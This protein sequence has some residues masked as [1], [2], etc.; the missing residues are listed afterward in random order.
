MSEWWKY[1]R[2]LF[3]GNLALTS[4]AYALNCYV[5]PGYFAYS[6]TDRARPAIAGP[7]LYPYMPFFESTLRVPL[8]KNIVG[9]SVLH[10]KNSEA[11]IVGLLLVD[12]ISITVDY[13][14]IDD[15]ACFLREHDNTVADVLSISRCEDVD[16]SFLEDEEH[17]VNAHM[18]A[19]MNRAL[20]KHGIHVALCGT[21]AFF[22]C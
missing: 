22:P 7:A 11:E 10:V 3:Y 15:V 5:P 8:I 18:E 21:Q 6:A 1:Y 12:S 4:G 17:D 20:N 13:Q 9:Q 19:I 14:R 2:W 16:F